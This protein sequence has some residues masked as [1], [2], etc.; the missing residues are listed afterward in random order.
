VGS[1]EKINRGKPFPLK[2]GEAASKPCPSDSVRQ[3]SPPMI[4]S[5]LVAWSNPGT[6]LATS[7][8]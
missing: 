8:D 1:G 4:S 7:R 6:D 2:C 5:R 3:L